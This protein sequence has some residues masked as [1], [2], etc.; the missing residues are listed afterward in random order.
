MM[1]LT[2]ERITPCDQGLVRNEAISLFAV[3][4]LCQQTVDLLIGNDSFFKAL[5]VIGKIVALT[6][7]S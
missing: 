2:L 6:L 5:R 3:D 7:S 1:T 4:L